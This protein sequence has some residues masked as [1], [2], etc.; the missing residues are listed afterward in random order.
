MGVA[1]VLQ[2]AGQFGS[3]GLIVAYL[4]WRETAERRERRELAEARAEIDRADIA[5]REKQAAAFTALAMVIQGRPH[6]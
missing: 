3:T 4:I 5:A 1:E 2:L 6:G